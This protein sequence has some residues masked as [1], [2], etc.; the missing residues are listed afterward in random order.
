[1]VNFVRPEESHER[2]EGLVDEAE[3]V[4]RRLELP[5]RILEMCTGDLGFTQAKK[6]DLEVWAPADDMDEGR[7]RPLAGGLLRLELRGIPGAPCRDPVPRGAPR[8]R[9]VPPTLNGSGLA[10]PRIVVAIL[11]TTRTT[12]APSPSPRRCA[13]T[14]A[15]QR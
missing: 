1:M 10:V 6:Y 7:G 3:E 14:W 12:T 11:S 9:G 4:L 2:F 15:A 13:R 8:V 5:Y